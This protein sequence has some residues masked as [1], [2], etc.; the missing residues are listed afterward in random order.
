MAKL[1]KALVWRSSGATS[2][3]DVTNTFFE[4][5]LRL[6]PPEDNQKPAR[7]RAICY[8][9]VTRISRLPGPK[10]TGFDPPSPWTRGILVATCTVSFITIFHAG[11]ANLFE[12][13]R[14]NDVEYI[15]LLDVGSFFFCATCVS[16]QICLELWAVD[17]ERHA[18]T[19]THTR[20]TCSGWQECVSLSSFG[21][22][23]NCLCQQ[24]KNTAHPFGWLI[25]RKVQLHGT[26][27]IGDQVHQ[28]E[29]VRSGILELTFV[30]NWASLM[31]G[32]KLV[33]ARFYWVII[34]QERTLKW[35]YQQLILSRTGFKSHKSYK[36]EANLF[37]TLVQLL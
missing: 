23:E 30:L 28:L 27:A 8:L 29:G 37:G 2:N 18:H 26:R 11:C 34:Y 10:C 17:P 22:P 1:E 6:F 33:T 32:M 20:A 19:H 25:D 13:S 15:W 35:D 31:S 21:T 16:T 24:M 7:I 9:N 5:F 14:P 36:K 4:Q 12:C 3:L